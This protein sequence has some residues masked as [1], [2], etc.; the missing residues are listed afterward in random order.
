MVHGDYKSGNFFY[1][2]S[3]PSYVSVIDWQWTGPGV[4]STDLIYLCVM[5]LSDEACGDY[6][7]N[8][9]RPYH[10]FLAEALPSGVRYP[11]REL[12]DEF[13]IAA[14]D[15]H[16]WLA[17]S[18]TRTMTVESMGKSRDNVDV[19]HGIWRRSIERIAWLWKL[20]D[21]ALDDIDRGVLKI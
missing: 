20:V 19:N 16:R 3:D 9:L 5:A 14:V 4:P 12:V 7:S 13:K 10:G 2:P 15:F 18:R 6:E 17:T 8:V 21:E 11:Y 1:D